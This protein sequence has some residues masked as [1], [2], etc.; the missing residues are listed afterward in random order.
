MSHNPFVSRLSSKAS[1]PSPD[2]NMQ[3]HLVA[4]HHLLQQD[5]QDPFAYTSS[6]NVWRGDADT[7]FKKSRQTKRD[8]HDFILG[9]CVSRNK[10]HNERTKPT[11]SKFIYVL[12]LDDNV[13]EV[14][15]PT[16]CV[17]PSV[18]TFTGTHNAN[19]TQSRDYINNPTTPCGKTTNGTMSNPTPRVLRRKASTVSFTKMLASASEQSFPHEDRELDSDTDSDSDIDSD[20]VFSSPSPHIQT[21]F[22]AAIERPA[23]KKK[24]KPPPCQSPT[25]SPQSTVVTLVFWAILPATIGPETPHTPTQLA[26]QSRTCRSA[27]C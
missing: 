7:L 21:K 10:E 1:P 9:A 24:R 27:L 26:M 23:K 2:T 8:I 3:S 16:L 13:E 25:T 19:D 4:K 12:D 14:V 6:A 18:T 11:G 17:V 20:D 22:L 5:S 15:Q